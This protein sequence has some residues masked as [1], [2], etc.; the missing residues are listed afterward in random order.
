M[1]MQLLQKLNQVEPVTNHHC[2]IGLSSGGSAQD[3]LKFCV[4]SCRFS[5]ADNDMVGIAAKI[6]RVIDLQ[7]TTSLVL[8]YC[9][10]LGS[11]HGYQYPDTYLS[12]LRFYDI[13]VAK[14]YIS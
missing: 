14:R 5:A 7:G 9:K 3:F 8:L 4:E 11:N 1:H 12:I 10:A 13:T 6:A 2:L